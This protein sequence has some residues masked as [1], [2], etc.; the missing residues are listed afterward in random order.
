MP[1]VLRRMSITVEGSVEQIL[2]IVAATLGAPVAGDTVTTPLGADTE[3]TL[4]AKVAPG[5]EPATA[6]IELEASS[7][8]E[9]PYFNWFVAPIIAAGIRRGLRHRAGEIDAAAHGRPA[10][11][12]LGPSRFLPPASFTKQQ[13]TLIATVAFATAVSNFG[14]ALFGQNADSVQDAFHKSTAQL[15]IASAVTR[16]GVLIALVAIG[17][18]DRVGR[19]KV[20][21]WSL[22]GVCVANAVSAGSP[23]FEIFTGGQVFARAF[24]N[25]ALVVGGIAVVE[26]APERARAFALAMLALAAGAGF[27]I[28]VIT[29]PIADLGPQAWRVAFGLSALALFFLPALRRNLLE[30]RRYTALAKRPVARGRIREV[31]DQAYGRRFVLLSLAAFLTNVFAAPSAQYTNKY[32]TDE[33]GFSNSSIALFR[34][35]TNGAPGLIG[36]VIAGKLAESRGRR[37]LAIV[38]LGLATVLQMAFFVTGGPILWIISTVAIVAAACASLAIATLDSELFP[39]E[40]RSTSNALILVCSVAGSIT[41]LLV[42]TNIETSVGGLGPAIALC[43]VGALVAAAFV[44]PFLPETADRTLDAVSPTEEVPP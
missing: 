17:L 25:A 40:V 26:E 36:I 6:A 22:V 20:I 23:T 3:A 35:V 21:L 2:P 4:Y 24:A 15:G 7:A 8:V 14:G 10:P 27:A 12:P 33:H 11:P 13:A 16:V 29:L 42:A 43:G 32:L 37:P 30:T 19:R 41:G 38:A 28:S 44:L 31:F 18:G 5:H 34:A 9:V 39:T 1:H